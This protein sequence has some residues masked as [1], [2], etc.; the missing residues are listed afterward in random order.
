LI[1]EEMRGIARQDMGEGEGRVWEE[2]ETRW[3]IMDECDWSSL[4]ECMWSKEWVRTG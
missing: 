4:R 3:E 1:D 2:G